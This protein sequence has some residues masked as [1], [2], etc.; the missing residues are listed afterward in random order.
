M[1]IATGSQ[2]RPE[3]SAVNYTPFLQ[4]SGQSAQ[5]QA[6]GITSAVGGALK[7]F[8][9]IVQQQKENKQLEAEI[10]SAERL[11]N[12]LQTFLKDV[13]PEAQTEFGKMIA[14][15]SDSNLS[16]R[17]RASNAK[18]IGSALTNIISLAEL[19]K[20]TK[21]RDAAAYVSTM[22]SQNN[23]KLSDDDVVGITP[24][25]MNM[26]RKDFLE[27]SKTDAEI[28][29]LTSRTAAA[30]SQASLSQRKFDATQR[31]TLIESIGNSQALDLAADDSMLTEDEKST[32]AIHGL[33]VKK[34]LGLTEKVNETAYGK[35]RAET[36][37]MPPSRE[38]RDE[39]L[40]LYDLYGGQSNPAFLKQ[41]GEANDA[42][43]E[44][45]KVGNF[46]VI[47]T[48]TT[49]H[50]FNT[51]LKLADVKNMERDD[52]SVLLN[53]SAKN[54]K[55]WTDIPTGIRE[56][57]MAAHQ[58]YPPQGDMINKTPNAEEYWTERR[59]QLR[60]SDETPPAATTG[61]S[62]SSSSAAPSKSINLGGGWRAI[63]RAVP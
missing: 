7:G 18:G 20:K 46:K 62:K 43:V 55:K 38:K 3:L 45:T 56:T 34:K 36:A 39:V 26:G 63:P 54:Y 22:L 52:Y 53:D 42:E 23:G 14:G 48:G 16:L 21:D 28:A 2:I 11:G 61:A 40:R 9:S 31:K 1:A 33:E 47:R 8:E 10:K 41:I 37:E 29:N 25:Q 12:S 27:K 30:A 58:K 50:V 13:S 24:E 4:A 17:E 15:V 35:A 32:A 51:D 60:S 59:L 44:E 6:Q 57:I 5:M 19:G 49:T